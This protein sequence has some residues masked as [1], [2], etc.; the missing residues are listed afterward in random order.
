MVTLGDL[1]IPILSKK[2]GVYCRVRL[3][4][5]EGQLH[6]NGGRC[7]VYDT[8]AAPIVN[9]R[10]DCSFDG[11]LLDVNVNGLG[12]EGGSILRIASPDG[13]FYS[14]RGLGAKDFCGTIYLL[15][16][17]AVTYKDGHIVERSAM[18]AGHYL[19]DLDADRFIY[20]HPDTTVFGL[21]AVY[22]ALGG[23]NG[24]SG[25]VEGLAGNA[26]EAVPG[27]S[28]D[29][30]IK[31]VSSGDVLGYVLMDSLGVAH[32]FREDD[33]KYFISMGRVGGVSDI[34][35]LDSMDLRVVWTR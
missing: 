9:L 34:S 4:P 15:G 27:Y 29:A 20:Y 35:D 3:K 6:V 31:G 32:N 13:S 21:R 17:L 1:L 8:S 11:G 2:P 25:R 7:V 18:G 30:V 24:N 26:V 5:F 33:V 19:D 10:G 23:D 16:D 14:M 28:V 22:S 12:G